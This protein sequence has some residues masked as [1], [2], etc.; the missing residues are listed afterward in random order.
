MDTGQ[1]Q[2]KFSRV[3]FRMSASAEVGGLT[4]EGT[5]ENLSMRG[6]F[7]ATGHRPALGEGAE[8]TIDL[9]R[10]TEEKPGGGGGEGHHSA[11]FEPV[12]QV[13]GKVVR[14]TETGV[15]FC[16][17]TID[18]DSYVHLKNIVALNAGDPERAFGEMDTFLDGGQAAP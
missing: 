9:T 6:M 1:G 2:R 12:I 14:I 16:F 18:S 5:V 10:P 8:I 7:M 11:E 15:A 17:D 13:G 4:L 3:D